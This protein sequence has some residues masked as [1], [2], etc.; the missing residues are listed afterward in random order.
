MRLILAYTTLTLAGCATVPQNEGFPAN[1]SDVVKKIKHD[2]AIYQDYDAN[3]ASARPLDNTCHGA[4]SFSI[5]S[6]KIVLTTQTGDSIS[7][8]ASATLPVGSV[9]FGPSISGSREYKGTQTT[10]FTLYPTEIAIKALKDTAPP[11]PIDASEYPIAAGLQQLR[12]GLLDASQISPCVSL[13]PPPGNDGTPS[14]DDGGMYT[15]GFTVI[16]QTQ[17]GANIKFALFSLGANNSYQRLA[18]NTITVSFKARNMSA[19]AIK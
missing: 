7:G 2:L 3:A 14:K 10:T 8:N 9:T 11:K 17:G 6:V 13:T 15:F 4:V 18:G 12:D 5:N 19:A 16:N 1:V